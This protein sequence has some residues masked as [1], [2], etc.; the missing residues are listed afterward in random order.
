MGVRLPEGGSVSL[1]GAVPG[2]TAV[3]VCLGWGVNSFSGGDFDLDASAVLVDGAGRVT[4]DDSGF[5]FY[6]NLRSP[7]GS[8]VHAGDDRTGGGQ[9]DDEVIRVS[10][11]SVPRSVDR[12]VFSV[13]IYDADVRAQ[14]FGGVRNAF[15][16]VVDPRGGGEIARFDLSED[17]S[18][19]T[20]VV[21][22]ELY[23]QGG[24]WAFR[25]VGQGWASGLAGIARHFGVN[26]GSE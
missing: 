8:V 26:V 16:R 23:R 11:D 24:D 9:G 21:F 5:V 15:I 12:I 13:S 19:E 1:T 20:A 14:N 4:P 6:N 18:V 2:L 17:A 25:A 22:G 3:D 10:L 7:D